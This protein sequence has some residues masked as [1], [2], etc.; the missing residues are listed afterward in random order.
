VKGP[1]KVASMRL[2]SFCGRERIHVAGCSAAAVW[3]WSG[4]LHAPF[5]IWDAA[6]VC[7]TVVSVYQWNR[8]TDIREDRINCLDELEYAIGHS[9]QIKLICGAA[10]VAIGLLLAFCGDMAKALIVGICLL[11]GYLYGTPILGDRSKRLKN[12]PF[13]KNL[14]S[15]FGWALLTVLYP[16]AGASNLRDFRVWLAFAYML[17]AVVMVEIIWDIRDINGDRQSGVYSIPVSV[18]VPKTGWVLCGLNIF[19]TLTVAGILFTGRLPAAWGII[20]LNFFLIHIVLTAFSRY[21]RL[22]RQCSHALILVQS[23]VLLGV[24]AVAR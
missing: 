17:I 7:A 19:S 8:L 13:M 3:A 6:I 21:R 5:H 10:V 2:V 16:A 15:G 23:V 9:G 4:L 18:G 14:S 20:L 12:I 1:L 24:G 11:L 22:Q